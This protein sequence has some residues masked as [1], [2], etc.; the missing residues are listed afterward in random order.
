S[1]RCDSAGHF[2][3][4]DHTTCCKSAT[5][6]GCCPYITAYAAGTDFTAAQRECDATCTPIG[7]SESRANDS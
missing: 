5:G 2:V 6:Y 4:P 7:A 1:V 3:C